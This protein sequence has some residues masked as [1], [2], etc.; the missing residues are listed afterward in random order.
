MATTSTQK[1]TPQQLNAN[2]MRYSYE[3]PELADA[4]NGT[5]YTPGSNPLNFLAPV[6][7]LAYATK[8]TIRTNLSFTFTP[9]TGGT[10]SL[11]AGAPWNIYKNIEVLFGNKQIETNGYMEYLNAY[12]QGFNRQYPGQTLGHQTT[13]IQDL[14]YSVPSIASGTNTWQFDIDVPLNRLHPQLVFGILPIMGT[15]TRLQVNLTP[16]TSF[17]GKDPLDNVVSTTGAGASISNVTG[18][19]TV[20]VWYRDYKSMYTQKALAPSLAGMPTVQ[21]I[22]PNEK[23]PLTSGSMVYQRVDNPYLF[24]NLTC[25]VIDGQSSTQ[26]CADNNLQAFEIDRAGNSSSVIRKFD[27]TNGDMTNYYRMVREQIGQ[28]LPDPGVLFFDAR[29]Q[30]GANPSN[31]GGDAYLNLTGNSQSNP[32]PGFPA[33]RLGWQVNTVS[34]TNFTPRV[35]IY[36]TI[37]QPAG[38]RL[39]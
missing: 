29:L 8:I 7:E 4:Q 22:K 28:D 37:I 24:S 31:L 21:V 30:N 19:V 12:L 11:N 38:V 2:F 3:Q 18:T 36:G 32:N 6:T 20:I 9:G 5:T 17:E 34:S 13:G 25:I 27:S 33:A 23:N 15:G 35:V 39:A 1:P 26:F 14:I 16:A 10:A